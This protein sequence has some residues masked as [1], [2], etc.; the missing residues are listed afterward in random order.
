V[1][2]G[3]VDDHAM[4]V[5]AEQVDL[6]RS[7]ERDRLLVAS[8]CHIAVRGEQSHR[9]HVPAARSCV[10][11]THRERRNPALASTADEHRHVVLGLQEPVGEQFGIGNQHVGQTDV[12]RAPFAFGAPAAPLEPSILRR[13]PE[14]P[15]GTRSS[16]GPTLSRL[17]GVARS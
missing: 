14:A 13:G 11:A 6:A 2:V 1:V 10:G 3:R 4:Q 8:P 16:P 7:P 15:H 17:P 12:H 5:V 9:L